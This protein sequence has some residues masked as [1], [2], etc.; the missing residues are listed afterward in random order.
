[1]GPQSKRGKK[2]RKKT[3]EHYKGQFLNTHKV[4]FMLFFVIKVQ[5]WCVELQMAFL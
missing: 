5:T 3:I 1:M 4:F 2:L